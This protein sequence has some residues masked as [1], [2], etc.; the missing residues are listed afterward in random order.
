MAGAAGNVPEGVLQGH[1]QSCGRAQPDGAAAR[2]L[3]GR[4]RT[5]TGGA[6]TSCALK[7]QL[8][9]F[10]ASSLASQCTH[11]FPAYACRC[12][13]KNVETQCP[14][15]VYPNALAPSGA[16]HR[17]CGRKLA[18][19]QMTKVN[20]FILKRGGIAGME[21]FTLYLAQEG[22]FDPM[23]TCVATSSLDR[24]FCRISGIASFEFCF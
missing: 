18:A 13:E 7:K 22:P 10:A 8:G 16:D 4:L 20:R 11:S 12:T 19:G 9:L 15:N 14:E 3:L 17:E 24:L 21:G 2:C 1:V 23:C 6:V 5:E